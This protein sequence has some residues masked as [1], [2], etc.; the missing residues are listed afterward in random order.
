MLSL[1]G[2]LLVL[3]GP[4]VTLGIWLWLR[5]R[6]DPIALI[7]PLDIG[8]VF[9]QAFRVFT[10]DGWPV[11]GLAVV[12]VGLPQIAS[13][14]ITQPYMLAHTQ[15]LALA[16]P[17]NPFAVFQ[18]MLSGPMLI[19]MVIGFVLVAAFY[20]AATLYLVARFEGA[21]L[22]IGEVLART[23][24]RILPAFGVGLLAYL[25]ML[26]GM[27]LF[28]LPGIVLALGWSVVI[29]VVICER[30][31]FF[32]SFTRSRELAIGSRGRILLLFILVLVLVILVSLPAGGLMAALNRQPSLA[33]SVF[34]S[35]WRIIS[36]IALGAFQAGVFAAL[37]I[38]LRRIRDGMT[39]P[40]LAE[41]FA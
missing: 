30:V 3:A 34:A 10:P 36:G 4:L 20:V 28:I 39:A 6:R 27:C 9:S 17:G 11:V 29:P 21:P 7:E 5:S 32:G 41:V 37:Y 16:N 35:A 1:V 14:L 23:P 26:A 31:G 38:E 12:L 13:V 40:G 22:T 24:G 15:Q 18:A 8:R 33:P 19:G 25:G 2:V